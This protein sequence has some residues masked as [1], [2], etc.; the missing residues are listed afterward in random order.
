LTVATHRAAATLS[1]E[2]RGWVDRARA[3]LDQVDLAGLVRDMT[4]IPSPTGDEAGLADFLAGHLSAAGVEVRVQPIGGGQAN[5]IGRLPGSGDG[6]TLLLYSAIDTPFGGSAGAD[7]PW[8]GEPARP[9]WAL[10]PTEDEGKVIGLGADNP[11]GFAAALVAAAEAVARAGVPLRGDVWIALASGSMPIAGGLGSGI[12]AILDEIARPDFAILVKPGYAVAHEEV[13]FAWFR[14]TVRGAL[15]YTGIRHKG[16]YRNPIVAAVAVVGELEAWFAEYTAANT[17]GL[18]A[19]QGSINAIRAGSPDRLAFVPATAQVDLDLRLGP[20]TSADDAESQLRGALERIGAAHPDIEVD[21]QRV[22]ALPGTATDPDS[23]IVRSLVA[24]W[25]ERE[26]RE[27]APLKNGSGASDATIIRARGIPAARIGPPPPATPNPYPG[28]SMGQ[29][30]I[31]SLRALA[32]ILVRAI[33]D[34]GSRSRA[35]VGL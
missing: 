1:A 28:F 34:T 18:V 11:K 5:A 9:D 23:W 10:P 27:H 21:L 2:Q 19:P 20:R 25:E 24:A 30:D 14:I 6:P 22:L 32:E 15:N 35:E 12:S 8:L 26:G 17:S 3:A 16:P 29:A 7:A 4:A 33:V 13:G 31:A